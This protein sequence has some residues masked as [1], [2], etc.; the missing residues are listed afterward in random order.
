MRWSN[1]GKSINFSGGAG[2][3]RTKHETNDA[4]VHRQLC[5]TPIL[6]C[7]VFYVYDCMKQYQRE[8]EIISQM[9]I[10]LLQL[11]KFLTSLWVMKITIVNYNAETQDSM[12]LKYDKIEDSP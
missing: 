9:T 8:G 4:Y 12:K 6:T 7:S 10:S 1:L 3:K 11:L 5:R 2:N